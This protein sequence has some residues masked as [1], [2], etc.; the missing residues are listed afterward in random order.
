MRH[1][2]RHLHHPR[3]LPDRRWY[4]CNVCV[5]VCF[6]CLSVHFFL[7]VWFRERFV[8]PVVTNPRTIDMV[9]CARFVAHCHVTCGVETI[10]STG[11]RT[12]C[13]LVCSL[14]CALSRRRSNRLQSKLRGLAPRPLYQTEDGVVALRAY[15]CVETIRLPGVHTPWSQSTDSSR[16]FHITQVCVRARNTHPPKCQTPTLTPHYCTVAKLQESRCPR[17]CV[18]SCLRSGESSSPSSSPPPSTRRRRRRNEC[19]EPWG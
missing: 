13:S 10:Q 9:A 14:Y 19:C 2:P 17:L 1:D 7:C 3:A 11:P 15:T 4:G 5:R 18:L 8:W 12:N 6:M 16:S